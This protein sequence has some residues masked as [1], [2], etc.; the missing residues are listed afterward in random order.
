MNRL[1]LK[2]IHTRALYMNDS[3]IR[4]EAKEEHYENCTFLTVDFMHFDCADAFFERCLFLNCL[5]P[6][7]MHTPTYMRKCTIIGGIPDKETPSV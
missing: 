4:R 1:P 3:H 5:L 2:K 6:K 7:T